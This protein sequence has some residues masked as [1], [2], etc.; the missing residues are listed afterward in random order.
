MDRLIPSP[1]VSPVT[2]PV[3][4]P[5]SGVNQTYPFPSIPPGLIG[6]GGANPCVGV[7]IKCAD[8]VTVYHFKQGD[9]PYGSIGGRNWSNC[10]ADAA[11][12]AVEKAG[13]NIVAISPASACGV[14]PNGEWYEKRMGGD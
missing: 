5:G 12:G 13:I 8:T 2:V 10:Q 3:P 4:N 7:V 6:V 9:D 14:L 1:R 11:I